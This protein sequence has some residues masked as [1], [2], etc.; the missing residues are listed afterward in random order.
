MKKDL[1]LERYESVV[2]DSIMRSLESD[3]IIR[4]SKQDNLDVLQEQDVSPDLANTQTSPSKGKRLGRIAVTGIKGAAVGA[5][6]QKARNV[7]SKEF[8]KRVTPYVAKA[9]NAAGFTAKSIPLLGSLVALISLSFNLIQFL[10]SLTAF[11]DKLLEHSG[12]ELSGVRSLIGEYSIIDASVE[13]MEKVAEG[14]RQN[15]K[16]ADREA[17]RTLYYDT[18][19]EFKDIL[20][21][22]LLSLKE[23]TLEAGLALAIVIK[24][25]PG[26]RLVKNILFKAHET[27]MDIM[28]ASPELLQKVFKVMGYIYN[29][30]TFIPSLM[31]VIGFILDVERIRAFMKID[32]IIDTPREGLDYLEDAVGYTARKGGA[33]KQD[34]DDFAQDVVDSMVGMKI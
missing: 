16:E 33:L 23:V 10:K 25:T 24:L 20:V 31:P 34:M 12:V 4:I 27:L 2:K 13:D 32:E 29:A 11:T 8:A 5:A 3:R 26:E 18:M 17:L 14:L 19:E 7:L 22:L 1:I 21:D 15:L 30:Q 6:K 28:N 9:M